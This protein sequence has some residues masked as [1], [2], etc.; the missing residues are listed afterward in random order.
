MVK[1][2]VLLYGYIA[3]CQRLVRKQ[4]SN[5]DHFSLLKS[6]IMIKTKPT[7]FEQFYQ[8]LQDVEGGYDLLAPKF[9]QSR[10]ITP[11]EILVPF[12]E[13]LAAEK[14]AFD[15][16]IDICCGSGAASTYLI[17]RCRE[18][19]TALDLSQGMLDQCEKKVN[20]LN[21]A[22]QKFFVKSDALDMPF[23]NQFDVAV[24]FGAFG[25][26]LAKDEEQFIAQVHKILKPGGHLFFITTEQL[27]IWSISLWRQRLFNALIW[28]RNIIWR[29]KFIMYYLTFRLPKVK[30][31]LE[32]HG[33]KVE[34]LEDFKFE[35]E[36]D[37]ISDLMHLKYFKMVKAEKIA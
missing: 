6:K 7:F 31:K 1:I 23:E 14:G 29:P 24:S 27:P 33:F 3:D 2:A 20:A 30:N 8:A 10:Y 13:K 17:K 28:V 32:S 5:F 25:H 22:T 34:V 12:F 4:Y 16:G 21:L 9:D 35:S 18:E 19:F 26:I 15:N 11:D 36:K 37:K